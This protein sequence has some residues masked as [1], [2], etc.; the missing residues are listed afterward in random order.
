MLTVA[1]LANQF[2]SRVEPYVAEEIQQLRRCSV[3]LIPCSVRRPPRDLDRHLQSFI[4]ETL[5]LFPPRFGV[6]RRASWLCM[7][8]FS[9]ISDLIACLFSRGEESPAKRLRALVHT[10]LGACYAVELR[11]RGVQHIH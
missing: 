5:Y 11:K 4:G 6:W 1:Y 3:R 10:F 7:R 2:P 9:A 8:K